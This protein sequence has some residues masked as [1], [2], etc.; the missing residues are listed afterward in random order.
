[1]YNLDERQQEVVD[2]RDSMVCIAGPG[3][4]KTRVLTEKARSL[5][6]DGNL[7]VC[8]CFTRSAA[9][10]MSSRVPHV[11]ACT[12]HSLCCQAVGWEIPPGGEEEEGYAYLLHKFLWQQSKDPLQYDWVLVDECQDLNPMELDVVLSLVKQNL[13]AVGD[14]YQSI[15]GFQGALGP[16]VVDIFRKCGC[17]EIP[18]Q[19]NYRSRPNIVEMLEKVYKRGLVSAGTKET[20][21]T[22]VLCRRNDQ[23]FEVSEFL[24]SKRV[25]HRV[26]LSARFGNNREYDVAGQSN[27]RLMTIHASKG[28]EFDNVILFDWYPNHPGEEE[29]VLYVAVARASKN[30]SWVCNLQELLE[31]VQKFTQLEVTVP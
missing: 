19:N 4:G 23:L 14:P 30:Y 12:I 22:A 25:P 7:I 3:S 16:S 11:P 6:E 9:M 17:E 24:K 8:L 18:L 27:L 1:M 31:E 2:S 20:S 29:R 10:E 13:F 28:H 5:M 21:L 15:Y 26:R